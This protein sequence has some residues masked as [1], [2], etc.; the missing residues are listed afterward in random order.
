MGECA[1]P[2]HRPDWL[3]RTPRSTGSLG[4]GQGAS[5]DCTTPVPGEGGTACAE[6]QARVTEPVPRL[7]SRPDSRRPGGA[8]PAPRPSLR[9]RGAR[10][11]R[12][13]GGVCGEKEGFLP[14][15]F[16]RSRKT[17]KDRR[18]ERSLFLSSAQ[19][20]SCQGGHCRTDLWHP[21]GIPR[22][23]R[24]SWQTPGPGWQW[25][26][27]WVCGTPQAPHPRVSTP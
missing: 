27:E 5:E 16:T 11:R 21:C 26:D 2:A 17:G 24:L 9:A 12:E 15:L 18:K 19:A 6:H 22:E 25:K 20:L 7:P 1:R 3:P 10:G 8:R 14:F 13:G 4:E 23:A